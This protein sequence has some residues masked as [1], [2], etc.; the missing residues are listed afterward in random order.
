LEQVFQKGFQATR[1]LQ[2]VLNLPEFSVSQFSP[3]RAD[4][5][6]IAQ[7]VEKQL[8]LWEAKAHISCEANEQHPVQSLL[9]IAAL[10]TRPMWRAEDASL[11]IITER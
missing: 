11:L 1:S 5:S 2:N 8:N 9:G 7:P 4:G 10:P 6:A 3:P